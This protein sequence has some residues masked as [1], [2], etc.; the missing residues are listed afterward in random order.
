[1][2]PIR[3][4]RLFSNL[5]MSQQ[6][7]WWEGSARFALKMHFRICVASRLKLGVAASALGSIDTRGRAAFAPCA[8]RLS[9]QRLPDECYNEEFE[10]V[11]NVC[12]RCNLPGSVGV[13]EETCFVENNVKFQAP[14]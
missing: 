9:S 14:Q 4:S 3:I 1:M 13:S 5:L 6:E 12:G 2:N 8:P 11:G 10:S 7:G